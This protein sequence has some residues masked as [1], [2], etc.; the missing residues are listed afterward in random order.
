MTINKYG[1]EWTV[2]LAGPKTRLYDRDFPPQ[3]SR[4]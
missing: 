3:T 2:E 4:L 1:V